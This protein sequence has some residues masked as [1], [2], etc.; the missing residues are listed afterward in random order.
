MIDDCKR[1][2]TAP[3]C[4]KPA[5]NTAQGLCDMAGNAWEWVQDRDH[6]YFDVMPNDGSAWESP[7]SAFYNATNSP[8]SRRV[9]RGGCWG[10]DAGSARSAF[11]LSYVPGSRRSCDGFRT[12]R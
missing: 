5:G 2:Y 10:N 3:V 12:A 6:G 1:G 9:M 11:R 7:N 8:G 4:S